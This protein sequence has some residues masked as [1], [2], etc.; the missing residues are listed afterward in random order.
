MCLH[1]GCPKL[2]GSQFSMF[3]NEFYKQTSGTS[4]GNPLSP[5]IANGFI[6]QFEMNL[7]ASKLLPH[8]FA[9]LEKLNSQY[10]TVKFTVQ[11]EC[12]EK[13]PFLNV[14]VRHQMDIC[15]KP[16]ATNR[17][18]NASSYHPFPHKAVVFH[19]M[20]YRLTHF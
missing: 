10:R 5:I 4:I 14:S 16:T 2:H 7:A 13:L 3:Q 11:E 8:I 9:V 17:Y 15:R 12:N 20:A 18:I 6:S 19:L 1:G